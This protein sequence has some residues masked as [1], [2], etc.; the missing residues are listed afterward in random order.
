MSSVPVPVSLA[1]GHAP[2][3]YKHCEQPKEDGEIKRVTQVATFGVGSKMMVL[4]AIYDSF[5]FKMLN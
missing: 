5:S 3:W 2:S 1:S 4:N